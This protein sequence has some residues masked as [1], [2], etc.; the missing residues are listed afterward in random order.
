MTKATMMTTT[1]T[2]TMR[3]SAAKDK[4]NK[5]DV[6]YPLLV[7]NHTPNTSGNIHLGTK[8]HAST[9]SALPPRVSDGTFRRLLWS[10]PFRAM[11]GTLLC[12]LYP[13]GINGCIWESLVAIA[14]NSE[15]HYVYSSIGGWCPGALHVTRHSYHL[16]VIFDG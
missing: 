7:V 9:E 6:Q 3:M 8:A 2:V 4:C 16:Q 1:L 11:L 10:Y 14:F 13:L 12:T 15:K 5:G